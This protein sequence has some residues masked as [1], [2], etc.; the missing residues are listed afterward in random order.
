MQA[1]R[2]PPVQFPAAMNVVLEFIESG[3][4]ET[5]AAMKRETIRAI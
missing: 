1:G 3:V 2:E 5:A 4:A